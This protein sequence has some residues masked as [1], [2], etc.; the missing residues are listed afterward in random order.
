[1]SVLKLLV[2]TLGLFLSVQPLHAAVTT[3]QP[4]PDFSLADTKAVAHSLSQYK[5]KYV[6]LEWLNHGC[7]FVKKHYESNNMQSLQ[8]E[9]TGKGVIWLSI[10]SSSKGKEGY[11]SGQEADQLTQQKNASP[12]AVLLDPK[13]TVGHL[14]AAKTTPHMYIINPEGIL[15]Y[16]GAIDDKPSADTADVASAKNYVKAALDQSMAGQPVEVSSTKSY[17]C[18]VK[19]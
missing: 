10:N 17:G 19:Y 8:K 18:G 5:G 11:T 13:G 14:Y 6:V 15:I 2:V 1:M 3:G 7:P 4:A 16:Q 9:F 12:T